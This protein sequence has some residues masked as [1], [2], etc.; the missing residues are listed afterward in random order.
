MDGG[1]AIARYRQARRPALQNAGALK[2]RC[3]RESRLI[4]ARRP[5]L[6]VKSLRQRRYFAHR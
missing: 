6:C 4:G 5:G 2:A 1:A 3:R